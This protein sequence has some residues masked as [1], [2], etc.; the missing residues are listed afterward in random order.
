MTSEV[1]L[2][3]TRLTDVTAL[4]T[5]T[6]TSLGD[7]LYDMLNGVR[8]DARPT[9]VPMTNTAAPYALS[10]QFALSS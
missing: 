6:E 1:A 10:G 5:Q 8:I 9:L 7:N 4:D 2:P 3:Q